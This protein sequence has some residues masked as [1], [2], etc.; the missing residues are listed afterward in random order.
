MPFVLLDLVA[1]R[2]VP[3]LDH[4]VL[5][6]RQAVSSPSLS[7]G[8]EHGRQI[9]RLLRRG[10]LEER[11]LYLTTWTAP[12]WLERLSESR[13]NACQ[14]AM[15]E[16]QRRCPSKD[17][18]MSQSGRGWSRGS[19]VDLALWRHRYCRRAVSCPKRRFGGRKRCRGTRVRSWSGLISSPTYLPRFR[20]GP[21]L[22]SLDTHLE[23]LRVCRFIKSK[24]RHQRS[25]NSFAL[26]PSQGRP[27]FRSFS[28]A[29]SL[30]S[31]HFL[32]VS[33]PSGFRI[34]SSTSFE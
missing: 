26:R 10:G 31:S 30:C 16:R 23:S 5:T 14:L 27:S 29:T 17:A 32:S 11:T 28:Q 8:Q 2:R 21:D 22:T 25:S 6:S 24:T 7:N 18:R 3:E 19:E 34:F 20:K 13:R 9:H 12:A 4:L 15:A 1:G 33:F